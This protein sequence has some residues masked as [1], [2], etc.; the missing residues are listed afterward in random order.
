MAETK[1]TAPAET[2]T[3]R[4]KPAKKAGSEVKKNYPTGLTI[5]AQTL[6]VLGG[7]ACVESINSF[8]RA[9]VPSINFLVIFVFI[10][11]GLLN[12]HPLSRSLAFYSALGVFI[13]YLSSLLFRT[14]IV[15]Q[16][17]VPPGFEGFLFWLTTVTAIGASGWALYTLN[18]PS[19]RRL[20]RS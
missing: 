5:L 8:L 19:V 7:I 16:G 14:M 6:V 13:F 15:Q 10:G 2:D 4:Q 11:L 1:P 3:S 12:R 17:G 20:F 9:S 18:R